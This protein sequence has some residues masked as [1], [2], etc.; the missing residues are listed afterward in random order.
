[1]WEEVQEDE[2]FEFVNRVQEEGG[3]IQ[4]L[5]NDGTA[6]D[7][8]RQREEQEKVEDDDVGPEFI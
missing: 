5:D 7:E 2:Q 1:M 6:E 3:A 4:A 8:L